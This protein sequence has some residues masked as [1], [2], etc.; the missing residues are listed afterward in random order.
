MDNQNK[1]ISPLARVELEALEAGREW[2]RHKIE[3]DLKELAEKQGDLSPP[4][5]SAIDS[6]P[7]TSDPDQ[8]GHR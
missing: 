6:E 4:E 7:S 1:R 2:I 3:N 8:D 5:Q